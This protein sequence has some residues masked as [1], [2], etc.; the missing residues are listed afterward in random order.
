MTLIDSPL[1]CIVINDDDDDAEEE[2]EKD[3][4]RNKKTDRDYCSNDEQGH[5]VPQQQHQQ[6]QQQ[7]PTQLLLP[8]QYANTSS[9]LSYSTQWR[10]LCHPVLNQQHHQ[11][12]TGGANDTTGN[13]CGESIDHCNIPKRK[14]TSVSQSTMDVSTKPLIVYG[15]TF[16]NPDNPGRWNS[17]VYLMACTSQGEIIIWDIHRTNN[18]RSRTDRKNTSRKITT[19]DDFDDGIGTSHPLTSVNTTVSSTSSPTRRNTNHLQPPSF[20]RST[21]PWSMIIDDD[22]E[23]EDVEVEHVHHQHP[24]EM[25]PRMKESF[26]PPPP[27]QQHR[28]TLLLSP[29]T[30][31]NSNV[32]NRPILRLQLQYSQD[33]HEIT[34][35]RNSMVLY[36]CQM[37][38][39]TTTTTTATISNDTHYLMVSGD[40][41]TSQEWHLL[42]MYS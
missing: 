34:G 35:H 9:L 15:L 3:L 25:I 24:D 11:L 42:Y 20:M 30:S 19:N 37:L 16:H 7:P 1:Q 28:P 36:H 17:P 22:E 5:Q 4:K 33:N 13:S 39:T 38:T 31:K 26:E 12:N 8:Y 29:N 10:L 27:P 6:Q 41:G 18:I 23:E 21:T 14:F 40:H 32:T 2:E